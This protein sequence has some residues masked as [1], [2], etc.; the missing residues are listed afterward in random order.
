MGFIDS[1]CHLDRMADAGEAVA[2]ARTA[3]CSAIVTAGHEHEANKK[4]LQLAPSFPNFVF[5]CVGIAPSVAMDLPEPEL[6]EHIAFVRANARK[7]V[8]IGEIGLDFHW[9]TEKAQVDREYL[10]FNAQLDFA[11]EERIP[12]VIHSRKAEKE[13]VDLLIEKGAKRVVLHFFSGTPDVAKRAADAG[14]LF[15]TPPVRSRARERLLSEIPLELLL[16][17]SDAPYVGKTPASALGA[18]E[19]IAS[20]K[21]ISI[22]DAIKSTSGN[23]K[24]FFGLHL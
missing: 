5:P 16:T 22:E 6:E 14:Y 20:A 17:E 24:R 7:C 13:C 19:L 12:L 15:T 9:P 10:A 4:A 18:A 8:A 11:L 3:G 2:Q 23:A 21:G 1:H